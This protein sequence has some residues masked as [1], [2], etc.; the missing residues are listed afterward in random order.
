MSIF[1]A[2]RQLQ[3][4]VGLK[5]LEQM[6]PEQA[7]LFKNQLMRASKELERIT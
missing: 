6:T 4:N 1:L 2:N 5:E 3:F 7:Y